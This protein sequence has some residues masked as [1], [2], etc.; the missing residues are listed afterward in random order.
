MT[1]AKALFARRPHSQKSSRFD[2]LYAPQAGDQVTV[3]HLS[4]DDGVWTFV[5]DDEFR[6]RRMEFRPIEGFKDLDR[7]YRS[8]I[9]FPFFAVRIP[10]EGRADIQ[11]RLRKDHIEHPDLSD[12]LRIF[13]RR[14][15]SSPGFE[16]VAA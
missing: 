10:D 8:K 12:M 4:Y 13:G 3:G 16:L 1:V 11:D 7:V 5:Y 9:L 15:V 6:G 14:V 2:L